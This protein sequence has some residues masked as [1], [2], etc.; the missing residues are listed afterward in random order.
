MAQNNLLNLDEKL[1]NYIPLTPIAGQTPDARLSDVTVRHLLHHTAGWN[2][3]I[4]FDPMFSDFQIAAALGKLLPITGTDIITYMSGRSL[5]FTPGSQYNYSN[6]G[7]LLLEQLFQARSGVSYEQYVQ[8]HIWT[9]LGVNRTKQG[10]TA[11][12]KHLANE[13]GYVSKYKGVSVL[14]NSGALVKSPYG[15]WN[16]ENMKAH[17]GWVSTAVDLVRFASAFDAPAS[18]P[19]LSQSSINTMFAVPPTGEFGDGSWYGA[20]WSVRPAGAGMNTWHFGSLPGTF[21]GLI[22]RSDGLNWAFLFNKRYEGSGTDNFWDID[23]MVHQA[24]DSI[25]NWPTHDLFPLYL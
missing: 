4:S 25:V 8:S 24:A 6:Y 5:N 22:R 18:S 10:K 15:A 14:D 21:T 7:Y 3:D 12:S 16:L 13:V 19:L 2:R 9:P 11:K 23:G 20:G 17:G 1:V